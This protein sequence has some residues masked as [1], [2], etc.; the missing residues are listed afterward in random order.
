[1]FNGAIGDVDESVGQTAEFP[2]FR[3][4]AL[5]SE[6]H[7]GLRG[8]VGLGHEA[9]VE[10]IVASTDLD[11]ALAG[12][13]SLGNYGHAEVGG[14]S[15]TDVQARRVLGI[16]ETDYNFAADVYAVDHEVI[17]VTEDLT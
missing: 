4:Y 7:F 3:Q 14:R 5:A 6:E 16:T 15:H 11:F 9:R 12:A 10:R 2:E 8:M 13:G 1:M 17:A